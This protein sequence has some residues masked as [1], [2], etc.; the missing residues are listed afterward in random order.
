MSS[1]SKRERSRSPRRQIYERVLDA[2]LTTPAAAR[3]GVLENNGWFSAVNMC[4]VVQAESTTDLVNALV[5]YADSPPGRENRLNLQWSLGGDVLFRMIP[6]TDLEAQAVIDLE[7]DDEE[8]QEQDQEQIQEEAA[9]ADTGA[10]GPI[11]PLQAKASA[12]Q[13]S[14]HGPSRSGYSWN[15][16]NGERQYD[17]MYTFP[18]G[19]RIYVGKA[20][21]AKNSK[22]LDRKNIMYLINCT[23]NIENTHEYRR[24]PFYYLRFDVNAMVCDCADK[25]SAIAATDEMMHF[26]NH[27]KQKKNCNLL[28]FCGRGCHRAGASFVAWLMRETNQSYENAHQQA[29][30]SRVGLDAAWAQDFLKLLNPE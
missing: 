30:L 3:K 13:L 17:L 22:R 14:G 28:F 23:Q 4:G 21:L 6:R 5:T 8:N 2:V 16:W 12:P 9:S 27:I 24:S 29:R 11:I 19:S 18:S 26:V 10:A 1:A 20:S 15:T 25:R 7:E